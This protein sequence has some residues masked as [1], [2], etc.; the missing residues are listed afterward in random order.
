MYLY[1]SVR[2]AWFYC[3]VSLRAS[4]DHGFFNREGRYEDLFT[5]MERYPAVLREKKVRVSMQSSR[6]HA[7]FLSMYVGYC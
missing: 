3:S 4:H 1:L 7:S 5:D 6:I 2:I